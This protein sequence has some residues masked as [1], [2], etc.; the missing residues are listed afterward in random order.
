[1][2]LLSQ[3]SDVFFIACMTVK[4]V[5]SSCNSKK[6]VEV[7]KNSDQVTGKSGFEYRQGNR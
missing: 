1:V 2:A 5:N 7:I 4:P 6:Q 3:M